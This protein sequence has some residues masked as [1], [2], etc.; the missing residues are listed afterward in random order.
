MWYHLI[1]MLPLHPPR[2]K[3]SLFL[4]SMCI[5]ELTSAPKIM[6]FF[7]KLPTS[8]ENFERESNTML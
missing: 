2:I 3:I 7:P 4:L 1:V 5:D 8:N 6:T